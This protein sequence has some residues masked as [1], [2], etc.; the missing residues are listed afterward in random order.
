MFYS[1]HFKPFSNCIFASPKIV[2]KHFAEKETDQ[3]ALREDPYAVAWKMK[4][5]D[6]L[7]ALFVGHIPR[8][9]SSAVWFFIEK[10]GSLQGKVMEEKF[11]PSPIPKEGLEIVLKAT[12][13]ITDERRK[14]LERMKEIVNENYNAE[15]VKETYE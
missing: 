4:R 11:K 1:G 7:K 15:G 3:I 10:G 2:E 8:K 14:I 9:L 5:K 6:K 13:S 12:F